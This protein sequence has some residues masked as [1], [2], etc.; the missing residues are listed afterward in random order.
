MWVQD[1]ELTGAV[2]LKTS[3]CFKD[4]KLT[5]LLA[6]GYVCSWVKRT[7]AND[8]FSAKTEHHGPRTKGGISP[9]MQ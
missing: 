6:N 1:S 8:R 5:I 7:S 2:A 4:Q 3:V 9:S